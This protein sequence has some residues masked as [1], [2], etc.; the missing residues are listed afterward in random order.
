LKRPSLLTPLAL[1]AGCSIIVWLT[2]IA[3]L[4]IT[5]YEVDTALLHYVSNARFILLIVFLLLLSWEAFVRFLQRPREDTPA[6][7][8]EQDFTPA[9]LATSPLPHWFLPAIFSL[10]LAI[11]LTYRAFTM[12]PYTA[13]EGIWN[14]V[15]YAWQHFG[16]PPYTGTLE[17]KTPGIF[18]LF[19]LSTQW[20]GVNFWFP[21]AVGVLVMVLT[22]VGIYTLGRRFHGHHVGLLAMVCYGLT[23]ASDVMNGAYPAET[24]TF[25]LAFTVL[26]AN[27][28][29]TSLRATHPQRRAGWLLLAGISLGGAV[30]FKQ[31]AIASALGLFWLYLALLPSSQRRW[32]V[33]VREGLLVACGLLLATGISL[34]PLLI[35]HVSLAD[36]WH[37]AWLIL[38]AP[39]SSAPNILVRI[40]RASSVME[41]VDFQLYLLVLLGTVGLYRLMKKQAMPVAG[42]LGWFALEFLAANASGS[43]F[44][45]QLRQFL[46][47]LALLASLTLATLVQWRWRG[48]TLKSPT[49]YLLGVI[50][51]L[52]WWPSWAPDRNMPQFTRASQ[53]IVSWV[54][55]HTTDSDYVYIFSMGEGNPLLA[56]MQRR[57]SSRFFTQ[58]FLGM[59][60]GEAEL[61][62]D[63]QQH[64]PR[65][66]LL[67]I[68]KYMSSLPVRAIPDWVMQL[69]TRDYRLETTISYL[70]RTPL[71]DQQKS[72][73]ELY[74]RNNP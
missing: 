67:P 24:E 12:S 44:G 27:L 63:L 45:H 62:R 1:L 38:R 50:V 60:G 13:D 52:L 72:G 55:T 6:A 30:A 66:L 70:E 68:H 15:G 21:R 26:A 71:D 58:Y 25:M 7:Q 40:W 65:Y 18:Y 23:S 43:Y 2:G 9:R 28:L 41:A 5:S 73:F 32:W 69:T 29:L 46:P 8:G 47:P 39:G 22:G 19:Y 59:P 56:F 54:A 10:V 17:N 31:I 37:G 48:E 20:F 4:R 14:Y 33:I 64:P 16:L 34:I 57:A 3:V 74:R 11:L 61:R 51:M 53:R 49:I 42:L 35:S 36:Y